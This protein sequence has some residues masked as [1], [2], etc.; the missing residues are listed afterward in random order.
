MSP[1]LITN[2]I[3]S[4]YSFKKVQISL[5][6]ITFSN[7]KSLL[8]LTLDLIIYCGNKEVNI[9]FR[10]PDGNST[11]EENKFGKLARG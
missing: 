8:D 6:F 7:L 4:N 10:M 5:M 11:L 2:V 9:L 1:K 3:I